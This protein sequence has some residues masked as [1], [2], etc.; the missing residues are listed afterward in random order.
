MDDFPLH[1]GA[2]FAMSMRRSNASVS[3]LRPGFTLAELLLGL[4]LS[5]FVGLLVAMMLGALE[6][7]TREENDTRRVTVY[8]QVLTSRLGSL[9]R[10]CA[11]VLAIDTDRIVLWKGD[12]NGDNTINASELRQISF[13]LGAHEIAT[14][15]APASLDPSSDSDYTSD[16]DFLA[17][18]TTLIGLGVLEDKVTARDVKSWTIKAD[19]PDVAN[20]RMVS[21]TLTAAE[22]ETITV[23]ASL[24]A[25][26]AIFLPE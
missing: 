24:R 25:R 21:M 20:V 18:A 17:V 7:S 8:R 10:T 23:V 9:V 13:D 22:L 26:S 4:M 11:Q 12:T 5:T 16:D 14:S 3:R 19:H 2:C 1:C 6:T 15:E